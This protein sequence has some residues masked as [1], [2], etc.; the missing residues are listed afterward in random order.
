MEPRV[1]VN[2]IHFSP[3]HSSNI[4]LPV[5]GPAMTVSVEEPRPQ[6]PTGTEV[7][8]QPNPTN[9]EVSV[10]VSDKAQYRVTLYDMSG[11]AVGGG[12][13]F[14]ERVVVDASNLAPGVYFVEL[15]GE[16][17]GERIV[18]RLVRN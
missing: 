12:V 13:L 9:G 3:S 1:A 4:T 18:K 8:L 11:A 14:Q 6:M 7:L 5:Y 2:G 10:Y 17:S 16:A 15:V